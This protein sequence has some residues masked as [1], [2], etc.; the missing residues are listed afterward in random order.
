VH[1]ASQRNGV[2]DAALTWW[3]PITTATIAGT[4]MSCACYSCQTRQHVNDWLP[5]LSNAVV[6][7]RQRGVQ[8]AGAAQTQHLQCGVWREEVVRTHPR[9]LQLTKRTLASSCNT[10]WCVFLLLMMNHKPPRT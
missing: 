3:Y 4:S 10:N 6:H 8:T 1:N 7:V 5:V 2:V 9:V